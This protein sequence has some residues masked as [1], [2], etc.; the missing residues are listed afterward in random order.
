MLCKKKLKNIFTHNIISQGSFGKQ[1]TT[2]FRISGSQTASRRGLMDQ[3]NVLLLWGGLPL[4]LGA[5]HHIHDQ[6]HETDDCH[7]QE[8]NDVGLHAK[9][10][11]FTEK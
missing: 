2:N 6:G 4:V 11:V 3:L 8:V 7:P 1:L 9:G 5:G 10:G